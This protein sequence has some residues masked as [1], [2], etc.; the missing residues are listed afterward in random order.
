MLLRGRSEETTGHMRVI[1][2]HEHSMIS[3][4]AMTCFQSDCLLQ[5]KQLN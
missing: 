1:L 3:I 5:T 4:L 2:Y